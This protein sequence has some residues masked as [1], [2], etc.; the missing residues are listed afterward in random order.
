MSWS[1]MLS[2]RLSPA[3]L[4]GVS[5]ETPKATVT[6]LLTRTGFLGQPCRHLRAP[7]NDSPKQVSVPCGALL[8]LGVRAQLEELP[9]T[10]A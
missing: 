5:H 10:A 9:I 1:L 3:V 6:P 4:L 2:P 8:A 7:A